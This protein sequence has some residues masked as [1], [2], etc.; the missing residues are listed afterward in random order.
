MKKRKIDLA[1]RLG[2]FLRQYGRKKQ[3]TGDPNDRQYDR[4]V[5]KTLKALTAEDYQALTESDAP[6]QMLQD[7]LNGTAIP[8]VQYAYNEPVCISALEYQGQQGC[9]ISLLRAGRN[10]LYLVELTLGADIEVLQ[11]EL[12]RVT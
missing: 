2:T 9:V 10:P 7:W 6:T 3:P 4:A 1:S 11:S 5:E 8:N 12:K